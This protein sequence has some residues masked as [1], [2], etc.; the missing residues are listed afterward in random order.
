MLF[1]G[2]N[3]F[4]KKFKVNSDSEVLVINVIAFG[5]D[6]TFVKVLFKCAWIDVDNLLLIDIYLGSVAGFLEKLMLF[7]STVR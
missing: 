7:G 3:G 2:E 5:N 1:I 4:F 6:A